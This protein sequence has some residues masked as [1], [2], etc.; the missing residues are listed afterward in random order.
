MN[1]NNVDNYIQQNNLIKT[2]KRKK[3][4]I[5]GTVSTTRCPSLVNEPKYINPDLGFAYHAH[6][7]KDHRYHSV[8]KFE[9]GERKNHEKKKISSRLQKFG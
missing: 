5:C 4:P 6:Y 8:T 1:H 7:S 2:S 9:I 3:N